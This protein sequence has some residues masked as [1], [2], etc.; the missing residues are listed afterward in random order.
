MGKSVDLDGRP[1]HWVYDLVLSETM[2]SYVADKALPTTSASMTTASYGFAGIFATGPDNR[3]IDPD[4]FIWVCWISEILNAGPEARSPVL[5]DEVFDCRMLGYFEA[6]GYNGGWIFGLLKENGVPTPT[7]YGLSGVYPN[8]RLITK[9]LVWNESEPRFPVPF[10]GRFGGS[11]SATGSSGKATENLYYPLI[12][13]VQIWV[14][15]FKSASSWPFP[16]RG[17]VTF[18]PPMAAA[19]A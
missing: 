5:T 11:A 4:D 8:N 10:D 7:M 2:G 3:R 15:A 9:N 18:A 1:K 19:A 17:G 13:S 14:L 12:Q 16:M 6:I